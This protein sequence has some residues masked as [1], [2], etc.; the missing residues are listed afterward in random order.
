MTAL[1]HENP[2]MPFSIRLRKDQKTRLSAIAKAQDRTAH[3]IAAK[4][5]SEFIER[6][7]ARLS[8]KNETDAAWQHYQETGLHVTQDELFGWMDSMFT[9]NQLPVPVCHK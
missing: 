9:D 4:A 8:F 7:E 5:L 6:E 1:A 2:L 3:S